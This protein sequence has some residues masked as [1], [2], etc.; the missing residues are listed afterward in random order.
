MRYTGYDMTPNELSWEVKNIPAPGEVWELARKNFLA[1]KWWRGP[2]H[3]DPPEET[4]STSI[5][6]KARTR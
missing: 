5:F 4:G 3:P 6:T 2:D 1:D